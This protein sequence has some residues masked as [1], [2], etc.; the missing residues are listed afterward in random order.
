M[1][2]HV[3]THEG[4]DRLIEGAQV[5][6][7][8]VG[9]ARGIRALPVIVLTG[10]I[11]AVLAVLDRVYDLLS[12]D[13]VASE[14]MA[15]WMFA[16]VGAMLLGKVALAIS[17]VLARAGRRVGAYWRRVREEEVLLE[18]IAADARMGT[19]LRAARDRAE[20]G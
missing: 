20:L 3:Q 8:Q 17:R 7:R 13:G 18:L 4:L 2:T 9:P 14:W 15:L 19:D 1:N 6:R 5:L 16:V 12:I 11:T 10:M